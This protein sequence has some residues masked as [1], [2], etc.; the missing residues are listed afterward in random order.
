MSKMCTTADVINC[1]LLFYAHFIIYRSHYL[2]NDACKMDIL[3]A[4]FV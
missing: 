2:N 1:Y 3:Y 4:F